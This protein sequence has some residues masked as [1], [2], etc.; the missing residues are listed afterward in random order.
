M[1]ACKDP[2]WWLPAGCVRTRDIREASYVEQSTMLLPKAGA[3]FRSSSHGRTGSIN[4][5]AQLVTPYS[6]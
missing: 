3:W 6:H 1:G 4:D 2:N 5:H